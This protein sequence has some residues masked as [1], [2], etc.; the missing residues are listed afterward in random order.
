MSEYT[1]EQLKAALKEVRAENK[2]KREEKL[3]R[4]LGQWGGVRPRAGRP[5]KSNKEHRVIFRLTLTNIQKKVL[6]EMG[7]GNI[8]VGLEKLISE[9]M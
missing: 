3:G 7:D 8:D 2:R 4:T 9:H 5:Y 1:E 6:M